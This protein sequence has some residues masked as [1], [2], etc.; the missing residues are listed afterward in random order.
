MGFRSFM[1]F[2]SELTLS[3][4]GFYLSPVQ[5]AILLRFFLI[6]SCRLFLSLWSIYRQSQT[7][8]LKSRVSECR[9]YIVTLSALCFMAS[10]TSFV[11]AFSRK[12]SS[13]II[14]SASQWEDGN[15]AEYLTVGIFPRGLTVPVK[16]DRAAKPGG[17]GGEQPSDSKLQSTQHPNR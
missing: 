7:S 5:R 6:C 15:H 9:S 2:N 8:E 1:F 17:W 14:H 13:L 16:E 11:Y 10:D 12:S 4:G 3:S